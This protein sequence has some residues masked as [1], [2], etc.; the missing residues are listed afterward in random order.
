MNFLI[1]HG[2]MGNSRENWQPWLNDKLT[3]LGHQVIMPNLS[4]PDHPTRNDWLSEVGNALKGTNPNQTIVIGH[5]LGVVTALDLIETL[6]PDQA[7]KSLISVSGFGEDYGAEL[8]SYFLKAKSIDFNKI[9]SNCGTFFVIYGDDDPYVPQPRLKSLADNLGV[10]P[11]IIPKDGHLN[12]TAGYTQF[13]K[14]LEII[15]NL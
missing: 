5:S 13:P 9:K 11:I 6:T 8:N 15:I 14:L 12:T 3:K 4:N 1:L 10:Q 2:I 7:I